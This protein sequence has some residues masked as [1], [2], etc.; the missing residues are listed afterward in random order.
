MPNHIQ[1]YEA[2]GEKGWRDSRAMFA[3]RDLVEVTP[4]N[5]D[6]PHWVGEVSAFYIRGSLGN[7]KVFYYVKRGSKLSNRIELVTEGQ[8]DRV[9]YGPGSV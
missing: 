2:N 7:T 6:E 1:W 5:T 9:Y 3:G 4:V 8:L